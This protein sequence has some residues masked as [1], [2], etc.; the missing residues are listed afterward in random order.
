MIKLSISLEGKLECN[1][2]SVQASPIGAP[3][4][5]QADDKEELISQLSR[6]RPSKRANAYVLGRPKN[7]PYSGLG[8]ISIQYYRISK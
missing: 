3:K 4:I 5:I 1:G 8:H 7:D 2:E 6:H